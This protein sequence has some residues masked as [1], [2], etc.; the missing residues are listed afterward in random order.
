MKRILLIAGHG[1]GDSGAVG[2]GYKEADLT[3]EVVIRLSTQ[4]KNICDVT[5]ADTMINWYEYLGSRSF[6]FTPY[7]YVLEIHFNSGGGTGTEIFVT[8]SEVTTGVESAI[9]SN[10][11]SAVGYRNRGVKRQNF[12]VI[13]RAKSQGVSAALLEV[14]FIDNY[15]DIST[16]QNKKSEIVSAIASGIIQG[17]G[18][19]MADTH[20][21]KQYL[22]ELVNKG[23]ITDIDIWSRFED[24]VTKAQ[25][26]ALIDKVTGGMWT[27]E[28]SN[29]LVHWSQPHVISLSG[30]GVISDKTQWL[31]S[32]DSTISKAM[33][34]ALI[35]K[36]TGGIKSAYEGRETDHWGRNH[37]DSL[38]DKAIIDTPSAW[39][40]FDGQVTK[41]QL[42]ALVCKAFFKE[43]L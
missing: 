1:A 38:C 6:D 8:N 42:M 24:A 28:E 13:S 3:R 15:S 35:D 26:I 16:Y 33:L 4:L 11:S 5:V 41:A 14:C 12:R 2:N 39:T 25:T 21:G 29:T 19:T 7:D 34:L 10:I 22:D 17:F 27:S 32:L 43:T 40:N 18:L 23:I 36:A 37:L 30:K 9:V 31:D 20:W